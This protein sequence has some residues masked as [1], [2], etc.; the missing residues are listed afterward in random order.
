MN[1]LF[2]S[3]DPKP[4]HKENIPEISTLISPT[5]VE[6]NE[7]GHRPQRGISSLALRIFSNKKSRL[8]KASSQLSQPTP[9]SKE[10]L[11]TSPASQHQ[12]H[13]ISV[14]S[15]PKTDGQVKVEK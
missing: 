9:P 14:S 6:T 2:N 5:E 15:E 11:K 7:G 12:H 1:S 13:I 3:L 10:K 4:F 8:Y